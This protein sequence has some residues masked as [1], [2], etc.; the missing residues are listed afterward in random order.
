MYLI[1]IA[2]LYVVILVAAAEDTIVAAVLTF[3]RNSFGNK[4]EP[5]TAA[6]VKKIRDAHPGRLM[7][8]TTDEL[9]KAHPMK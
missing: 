9:L 7:F 3:V 6:Q 2:W 1:P 5:I 8:F 4:A